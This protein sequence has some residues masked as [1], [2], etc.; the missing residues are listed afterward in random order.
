MKIKVSDGTLEIVFALNDSD[1]AQ[2]LYAVLPFDVEVSNYSS[3]EKIFYP[4]TG[5]TINGTGP[6]VSGDA[7]DLALFSPWGNVVMYYGNY[8]Q[9]SGLYKLGEAESGADQI[10]NLTGTLHVDKYME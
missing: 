6:Q 4:P 9:Y 3:N 5:V 2:S 1:A 7:G 8:S 10:P